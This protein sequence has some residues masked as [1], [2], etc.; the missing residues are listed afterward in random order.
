MM[1]TVEMANRPRWLLTS[2]GWDAAKAEAALEFY[3]IAFKLGAEGRV[4][5]V[6]NLTLE[7]LFRIVEGQAAPLGAQVGMIVR[8]EEYVVLAA[9]TGCSPEETTHFGILL[10]KK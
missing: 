2:S 10:D 9:F 6:V 3:K 7:A 4:L 5:N 8:A 1:P